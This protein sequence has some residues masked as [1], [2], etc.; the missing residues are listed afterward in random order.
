[1]AVWTLVSGLL[2]LTGCKTTQSYLRSK[3]YRNPEAIEYSSNNVSVTSAKL[4]VS[5]EPARV[6]DAVT[7]TEAKAQTIEAIQDRALASEKEDYIIQPLDTLDIFVFR[8][9]DISKEY[10]VS[11][12]GTIQ[13][14]LLGSVKFSGLNVRQAENL[15]TEK[16]GKDYLNNPKLNITVK[17]SSSRRVMVFGEVKTPGS[18]EI[19]PD[20]P[21]T[22][23]S[24]IAKA[25]GFTD[26]AAN[27]RVRIVR[28]RGGKDENF[29]INVN[30]IL[31]GG[32]GK[33]MRLQ[34][35]DVI[36]VPQVNF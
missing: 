30:E 12:N 9:P 5:A 21:F 36:T 11:A 8:E 4:N 31:K 17:A 13:H 26:L 6:T 2:V 1:M 14:P 35:G 7:N 32:K 34:T 18:F 27:E 10:K 3:S 24:A 23:L 33:D 16:L 20:Q 25:G 28:S 29:T 22:L 15:L 19:D